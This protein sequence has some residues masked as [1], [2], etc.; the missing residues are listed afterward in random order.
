MANRVLFSDRMERALTTPGA[1]I[2]VLYC[3]LDDFKKVN[4]ELG[5]AAGDAVLQRVAQRLE[6]C[7]RSGDTV[8]RLG[9]DEFAILLEEGGRATVVAERVVAAM[10]APLVVDGHAVQTSLSVGISRH[11][12]P[13]VTMAPA[14]RR[15]STGAHRGPSESDAQDVEAVDPTVAAELLLRDADRA[16]YVAKGT[17]KSRAVLARTEGDEQHP[18]DGDLPVRA[19]P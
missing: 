1:H 8:A 17:G 4:D 2:G 18:V 12:N 13:V 15:E 14:D 9:G 19:T 5:H 7:V 16:M 10:R 3:D 11:V 6:G